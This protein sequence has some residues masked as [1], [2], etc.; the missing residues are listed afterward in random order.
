MDEAV[1]QFDQGV[2]AQGDILFN[3][4]IL[5]WKKLANSLRLLLALRV[6]NVDPVLGAAEVNAALAADGGVIETNADNVVLDYPGGPFRHPYYNIYLRG[7]FFGLTTT[8]VGYMQDINDPRLPEYGAP[9]ANGEVLGVPYGLPRELA[10]E[11]TSE[12]PDW[13]LILAPKWRQQD[14]PYPLLTAA[15]IYLARA[16]A[17]ALNWTDEDAAMLYRSGLQASMERW[18]VYNPAVF[19]EYITQEGVALTSENSLEKIRFQRYLSFYPNGYQGWSIWRRTDVPNLQP[20]PYAVN[21]SGQ[22]P[23]RYVYQRREANLNP[24]NYQAAVDRMNGE[25]TMDGRVW[26]DR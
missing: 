20:T 4:N 22:I 23:R 10:L 9:N 18:E 26:W 17:A 24:E 6:S 7:T 8:L 12:N 14:T 3:G 5:G 16:E 11:Y 13:S 25:D 19:E 21:T 2:P 15:D 1:Q